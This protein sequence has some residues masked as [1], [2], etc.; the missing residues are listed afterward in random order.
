MKTEKKKSAPAKN[1]GGRPRKFAEPSRPITVTLPDRTLELLQAVDQDRAKAITKIADAAIYGKSLDRAVVR[2]VEIEP[3]T[4][5]IVV[6]PSKRLKEIPWL[7]L[8]ARHS[9]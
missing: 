1:R 3:G 2:L 9:R 5:V 7:R 8:A 4:A 6:A